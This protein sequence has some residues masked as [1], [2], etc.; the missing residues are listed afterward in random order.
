MTPEQIRFESLKCL[1]VASSMAPLAHK[2][3]TF[4]AAQTLI[5]YLRALPPAW[6]STV[7]DRALW[8]ALLDAAD[9]LESIALYRA[10]QA[11]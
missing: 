3:A 11:A 6:P 1:A 4:E 10:A 2:A 5:L 8:T 9:T 7:T